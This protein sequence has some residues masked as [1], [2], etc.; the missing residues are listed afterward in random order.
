VQGYQGAPPT[1]ITSGVKG[2]QDASYPLASGVNAIEFNTELFD[3]DNYHSV[4]TNKSKINIT[5][6]GTYHIG[7]T[8]PLSD[9][10]PDENGSAKIYF[11]KNGTTPITG[12]ENTLPS[13]HQY[14]QNDAAAFC[15]DTI[16]AL[17]DG[18][19]IEL[20]VENNASFGGAGIVWAAI[21]SNTR[22]DI[23]C[24]RLDTGAEGPIGPQGQM[25]D[26]GA[27]GYCNDS[28]QVGYVPLYGMRYDTD[29]YHVPGDPTKYTIPA[30][31]G[32]V[33]L[34]SFTGHSTVSNTL[35]FLVR[36]AADYY[37][38]GSLVYS[39]LDP[40]GNLVTFQKVVIGYLAE[41]DY[42]RLYSNGMT[43]GLTGGGFTI[44]KI[45]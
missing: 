29:G 7:Y 18:D 5:T 15:E 23:Y 34:V 13:Y 12:A 22:G 39:T 42:I 3:T 2:Y 28:Q 16:V 19:Y 32:G 44:R 20:I 30:G 6:T 27:D 1:S 37:W 45:A 33:Y 8:L 4:L 17:S 10:S 41:G 26:H 14:E 11:R 43:M 40:T 31:L 38:M 36:N 21:G 9:W 24:Y 25:P 35:T